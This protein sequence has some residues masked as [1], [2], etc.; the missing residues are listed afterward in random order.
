MSDY[1]APTDDM[2][3]VLEHIAGLPEL[4]NR[5]GYDHA[6]LETVEGVLGEAARFMEEQ[7]APLNQKGDQE[8]V[9]VENGQIFHPDGFADAY[10]RFVEAGWNGIALDE[11]HGG[12]GMPWCVG[13]AVQEMMTAS[14]MA[15]SLCPLLTQGA[16]DAISHHAS[17]TLQEIYL[18]KMVSGEWSGTMNLTEPH[19]G[20]DVGA[21]TTKAVPQEDGTWLVSGT[22]IFIT[23]GEHELSENIIHLVLARTPDAP[24]GTK[25]ISLFIVPKFLV[26]DDGSLG[27]RND[28]RVVSS[29]HKI[30]IHASPTCVMSYGDESG[31]VGWMVGEENTGMGAMF[32]MMNNARLSVGLQGLS[33]TDRSYQQARQYSLDRKQGKAIGAQL[34]AGDSSPIADHADVRRMLMTMRANA[35]AMRC[36]MYANAAAIDFANSSDDETEREYWDAITALL[37]PI[38]KGWGT[39][40]GVEM[41]SLGVQTHGGMGYVEETGAAQHWRDVRIAPIY[42]GTNGIQAADLVFRKLPLGGGQVLEKFISEIGHLAEQLLEDD[43]LCSMG[44]ALLDGKEQFREAAVWLGGRLAGQPNDAAAGSVPFMRVAGVVVGAYYLARSAQAAR[45]L[46]DSGEGDS[47]FL[48]DKITVASFYAEQILPT[49]AGLVPTITQGADR[50]F[51]IPND[52]L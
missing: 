41:T 15:F 5:Q 40:V 19:A 31:A 10:A 44:Q 13:L 50:F 47:D 16:I 42:E 29:E 35:E 23:Y 37:T 32:T 12:G 6:D 8:G 46:L 28:L 1:R 22:K 33:L 48:N 36:V 30:G 2:L 21:L 3:F 38:S 39:D 24:P 27:E 49:V 25:G 18:P 4:A 51:T 14:N 43:R 7:L 34:E 17:E 45:Q 20:S 52:R 9:V 11:S 26:N